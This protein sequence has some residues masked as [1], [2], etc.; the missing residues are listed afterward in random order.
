LLNKN[1]TTI[2]KKKNS[3]KEIEALKKQDISNAEC[4]HDNITIEEES[5]SSF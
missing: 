2:K 1:K 5:V 4:S 3:Q